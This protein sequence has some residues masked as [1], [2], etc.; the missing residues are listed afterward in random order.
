MV[1]FYALFP[2]A[3]NEH[4]WSD[5]ERAV[6]GLN[7][8]I[9]FSLNEWM[10]EGVCG[11]TVFLVGVRLDKFVFTDDDITLL[12]PEGAPPVKHPARE[13]YDG[14]SGLDQVRMDH[15]LRSFL[16][17]MFLKGSEVDEIK[18][19][20]SISLFGDQVVRRNYGDVIGEVRKEVVTWP[21]K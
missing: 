8:R 19:N 3:E 6:R 1:I 17:L 14:E 10:K 18:N 13:G 12:Q 15:S 5:V 2:I 9:F 11:T 21:H 4:S 16:E 20:V 7:E